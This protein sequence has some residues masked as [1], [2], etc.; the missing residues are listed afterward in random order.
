VNELRRHEPSERQRL[1]LANGFKSFF[2]FQCRSDGCQRERDRVA[3][4]VKRG[5]VNVVSEEK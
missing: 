5:G 3:F 4:Y 2:F 1:N